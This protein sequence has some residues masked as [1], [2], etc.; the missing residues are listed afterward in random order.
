MTRL[1]SIPAVLERARELVGPRLR[2]AIERL[3][4]E[5]QPL[6]SYHLGWSDADGRP[7]GGDG[8]KGVRPALALLSAEAVGAPSLT[9]VPGGVAIELVHNFS[10]IHDDVIDEDAERRHRPTIWSLFGIGRAVIV[11]D[12]LLALAQQVLLDPD[13][14]ALAGELPAD[15]LAAAAATR[16]LADATAA[17]I[18]GQA[19]DMAFEAVPTVDVEGCL[20]MEAGKTGALLGC[21]ASIGA[22]SAG[23]PARQVEGL[24]SFG[25]ELGLAF[26]AID[27]VLGIWGDPAVTGKPAFS[28]LYQHKKSLPVA[29]ALAGGGARAE[30]LA[31]L[32]G[33]ESLG[34]GEVARAAELVELAGGRDLAEAEA[35]RRFAAAVG[36]LEGAGLEPG[37]A[38]ELAEVAGFVVDRRF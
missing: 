8:G 29:A 34:E 6:A 38:E 14:L 7:C 16:C 4:P 12:A 11:G 32:L 25:L 35:R 10:L 18:A 9:G 17:M 22:V 27:D 23:A 30:E 15:P 3:S 1:S 19:L 21:A 5:L 13:L 37:P 28:D 20:A 36:A 33:E 26:Q 24:R 31:A 2:L